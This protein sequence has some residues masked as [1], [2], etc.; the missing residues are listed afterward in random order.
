MTNRLAEQLTIA[1][2][3][4]LIY[5]GASC[6]RCHETRR[7]DLAQLAER[8]GPQFTVGHIRQRLRCAKCGNRRVIIVT[9]WK[10]ATSSASMMAHW[11]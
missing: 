5:Y 11:K 4:E 8:L 10:D 6:N 3:R 2:G 7:V 1:E 9:L